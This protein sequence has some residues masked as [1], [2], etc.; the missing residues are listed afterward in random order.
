MADISR[1][2][3]NGWRTIATLVCVLAGLLSSSLIVDVTR[4]F[5]CE[6]P[7]VDFGGVYPENTTQTTL[8]PLYA[9]VHS[10]GTA[11][12]WNIEWSA[13]SGGPWQSVSGGVGT[14]PATE[15]EALVKTAVLTGLKPET[16]YFV[17]L[18]L[19]NGC[20]AEFDEVKSFQT[21]SVVPIAEAMN[22]SSVTG[23]SASVADSVLPKAR[24][25]NWKFEY[26]TSLS[27]LDSGAGLLGPEG[28][29]LASEASEEFH[30]IHGELTGLLPSDPTSPTH[31]YIR[32]V[33]ENEPEPGVKR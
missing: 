21:V 11:V 29:I 1:D 12:E 23:T 8:G 26:S 24:E 3:P 2:V 17:R 7:S 22:I 6:A 28:V 30:T 27:A 15:E 20:S 4:A 13:N 9:R 10:N 33:V 14:I 31:Y 5:S 16:I 25:T 18:R 19:N 32:V